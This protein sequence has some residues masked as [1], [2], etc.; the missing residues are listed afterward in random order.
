M[1]ITLQ[2]AKALKPG[3][4]LVDNWDKRWRVTSVKTW[5]TRPDEVRIGLK[6]GMYT[7]TTLYETQLD[8][9]RKEE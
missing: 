8:A 3:D 4:V 7:H 2:E 1:P 5:K 9:V 6:H